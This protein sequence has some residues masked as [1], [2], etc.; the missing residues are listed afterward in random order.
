MTK[1]KKLMMAALAVAALATASIAASNDASAKPMGGGARSM[2]GGMG[3]SKFV[4][5][6]KFIGGGKFNGHHRWYGH[7]YGYGYGSNSCWRWTPAGLVNV[8]VTPY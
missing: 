5:S 8:C 3:G 7:R 4:N 1:T 6:G 2:S